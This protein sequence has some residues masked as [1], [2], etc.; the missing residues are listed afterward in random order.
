M[1][2][3]SLLKTVCIVFVFCAATVI[4]SS[5][6]TFNTL[7]NFDETD[8]AGPQSSLIQGT[9]GNFYGTTFFGGPAAATVDP[10]GV[11][12]SSK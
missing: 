6:Q 7:V 1:G 4:A 11:A 5:A 9:D 12:R 2:K 10:R 3:L 8:G